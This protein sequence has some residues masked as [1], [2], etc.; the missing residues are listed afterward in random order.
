MTLDLSRVIAHRGASAYAPEN[1]LAAFEKAAALGA[2]WVEFDV[3]LAACGEVIVIHDE[4]LERTSNGRGQVGQYTYN[5]LKTLDAGTWFD[6]RFSG[7]GIPRLIDVIDCLAKFQL[8]A[9][10]EIKP[11]PGQDCETAERALSLIQS[12]WPSHCPAPLVSS[13]SLESLSLIRQAAPEI[14]LG[15]LQHEWRGDWLALA[16]DLNCQSVHLNRKIINAERVNDIKKSGR[17]VLS[18]TVNDPKQA[19]EFFNMGVDAVFTDYPDLILS[20]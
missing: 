10:I 12:H 14:A 11:L 18:Y 7:E 4:S 17:F 20:Y 5:E 8:G 3:M 19:S 1:T 13:F 2:R 6:A 15:L 9:N 16:D